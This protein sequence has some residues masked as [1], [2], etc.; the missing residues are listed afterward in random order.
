MF[1]ESNMFEIFPH[2]FS[3]L[4][5]L[6]TFPVAFSPFK[7]KVKNIKKIIIKT[8]QR[9]SF[10]DRKGIEGLFLTRREGGRAR[11]VA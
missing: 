6:T 2:I 9:K 8:I 5:N 3:L 4:S 7:A 10:P 1:N 11:E